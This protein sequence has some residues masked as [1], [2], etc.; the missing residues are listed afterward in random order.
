MFSFYSCFYNESLVS[1]QQ[2]LCS[3][4]AEVSGH[5]FGSH[6]SSLEMQQRL[7][8][9]SRWGSAVRNCGQ[10]SASTTG[11]DER[12]QLLLT[13]EVNLRS[14]F[15]QGYLKDA[16]DWCL[17]T[18][19]TKYAHEIKVLRDSDDIENTFKWG[20]C[21]AAQCTAGDRILH[22]WVCHAFFSSVL[23]VKWCSWAIVIWFGWR[24]VIVL[25]CKW[26]MRNKGLAVVCGFWEMFC[27]S[28]NGW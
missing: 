15:P 11:H 24:L 18:H 27:F 10:L 12:S 22:D 8:K 6:S 26:K 19:T 20:S 17:T 23:W 16:L 3:L 9:P 5:N 2:T 14:R 4:S 1:H 28:R 13:W 21:H 25:E 7:L